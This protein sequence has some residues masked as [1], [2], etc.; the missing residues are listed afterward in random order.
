MAKFI[1]LLLIMSAMMAGQLALAATPQSSYD[2][3]S[4]NVGKWQ[5][6]FMQTGTPCEVIIERDPRFKSEAPEVH[7][8]EFVLSVSRPAGWTYIAMLSPGYERGGERWTIDT[9]GARVEYRDPFESQLHTVFRYDP[10]TGT[11]VAAELPENRE[12]CH[13]TTVD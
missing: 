8:V 7:P 4:K 3:V 1:R 11:L 5:G 13:L 12:S 2:F 9:D 10:E 6:T